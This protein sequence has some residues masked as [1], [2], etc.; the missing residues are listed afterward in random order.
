M[1]VK[2]PE[3][4]AVL[5]LIDEEYS[6]PEVRTS[7]CKASPVYRCPYRHYKSST[8]RAE[9]VEFLSEETV[10]S[11]RTDRVNAL[12]LVD[13]DGM[14]LESRL[15]ECTAPSSYRCVHRQI[16]PALPVAHVGMLHE[17]G[18]MRLNSHPLRLV[19]KLSEP[20]SSK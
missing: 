7:E 16:N 1:L 20:S 9:N 17:I 2:K 15:S 19:L 10:S 8:P 4:R 13:P 5:E 12:E 3:D 11:A 6:Y 14:C 18:S